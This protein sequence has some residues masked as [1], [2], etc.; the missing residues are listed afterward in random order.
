MPTVVR[1]CTKDTFTSSEVSHRSYLHTNYTSLIQ[2]KKNGVF[3]IKIPGTS[4]TYIHPSFL[5]SQN[6]VCMLQNPFEVGII[7]Q[8]TFSSSV[9]RMSVITRTLSE[10]GMQLF[11]KGAPEKIA[12]LCQPDTGKISDSDKQKGLPSFQTIKG[13]PYFHT[14]IKLVQLMQLIYCKHGYHHLLSVQIFCTVIT[15]K[16]LP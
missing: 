13:G 6:T 4:I 8:F 14:N 1:P 2:R 3:L 15:E 7:R 9:Q 10:D 16:I 12:S 11:C 5:H